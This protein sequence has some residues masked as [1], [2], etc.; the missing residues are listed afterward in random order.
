MGRVLSY[1]KKEEDKLIEEYL[2]QHIRCCIDLMSKLELSRLGKAGIS[3]DEDFPNIVRL[4]IVFHDLGKAFYRRRNDENTIYFTGHEILSA[5]ILNKFKIEFTRKDLYRLEKIS[6]MLKP[7]LFAVAFHHHPMGVEKRLESMGKL[8]R[9]G[10]L[11]LSS[12]CLDDLRNELSY[13]GNILNADEKE[14]LNKVLED[15]KWSVEKGL[16]G[17]GEIKQEFHNIE[18]DIFEYF[19]SGKYEDVILKKLSYLTLTA[20]ISADY[21]SAANIRGGKTRF[22]DITDEFYRFYLNP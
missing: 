5:Y 7:A 3:L 11:K 2:S 21:I 16:L 1:Y 10:R 9:T 17:I 18:K 15:I 20:L 8:E 12:T 22:G 4:S 14:L 6:R 19:T 13:I